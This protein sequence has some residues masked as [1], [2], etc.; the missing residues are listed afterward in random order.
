VRREMDSR[1]RPLSVAKTSSRRVEL[2]MNDSRA[3]ILPSEAHGGLTTAWRDMPLGGYVAYV[4]TVKT[5]KWRKLGVRRGGMF[6]DRHIF[7]RT[8][9]GVATQPSESQ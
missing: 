7:D 2:R 4:Y 5:D 3:S 6:L 8:L 1:R 9:E